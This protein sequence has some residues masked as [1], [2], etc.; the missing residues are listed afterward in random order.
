MVSYKI[1]Q[2]LVLIQTVH[3]VISCDYSNSS[4][5]WNNFTISSSNLANDTCIDLLLSNKTE[6]NIEMV[7]SDQGSYFLTKDL[8]FTSKTGL[9]LLGRPSIAKID[10]TVN[11]GISFTNI[12]NLYLEK[13]HIVGCGN[14]HLNGGVNITNC[15]HV[16][17]IT[18]TIK[19]SWKQD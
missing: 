15:T 3:L 5:E 16:T 14:E 7:F 4:Q 12:T 11:T 19:R 1:I 2:L 6:Y 8:S 10:C 9:H 17:I 13:L 18:V